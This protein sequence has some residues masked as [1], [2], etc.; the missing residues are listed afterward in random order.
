MKKRFISQ[1]MFCESHSNLASKT[2]KTSLAFGTLKLFLPE[3]LWIEHSSMIKML[4]EAQWGRE[5]AKMREEILAWRNRDCCCV[6]CFNDSEAL[7]DFFLVT[8]SRIRDKK[9]EHCKLEQKKTRAAL[10]DGNW[11]HKSLPFVFSLPSSL[12][13]K[14]LLLH[15]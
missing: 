13:K 1:W 15:K 9:K 10:P 11:G 8:T 12:H 14:I 2:S 4:R 6:I 3:T 5:V 7:R